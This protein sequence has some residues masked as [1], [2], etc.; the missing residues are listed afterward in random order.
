MSTTSKAPGAGRRFRIGSARGK[1]YLAALLAGAAVAGC[2]Y[3]TA[4][5][6][7]E[8]R[9]AGQPTY[10]G[11]PSYSG[12]PNYAGRH[13]T[14]P[15]SPTLACLSFGAVKRNLRVGVSTQADVLRQLGSPNNMTL[16]GRGREIWVYDRIRTEMETT[17]A[18]HSAGGRIG[19]GALAGNALFGASF[20]AGEA[21][22]RSSLVSSTKTLTVI[23][24]FDENQVLRDLAVREGRY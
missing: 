9:Y 4:N 18:S 20:G 14:Q 16:T 12:Q 11:Q 13:R 7:D 21:K 10:A 22:S 19:F 8:P 5:Y 3:P 24:E 23:L 17:G 1:R 6:G 2:A 15:V